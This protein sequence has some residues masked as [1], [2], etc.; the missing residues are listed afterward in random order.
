MIRYIC[1]LA[2]AWSAN[3]QNFE[4][5]FDSFLTS[6]NN[7]NKS[8]EDLKCSKIEPSD[9]D[10]WQGCYDCYTCDHPRFLQHYKAKSTTRRL[11]V[12]D[13]C[14]PLEVCCVH[15]LE[16]TSIRSQENCGKSN[17]EGEP[18]RVRSTLRSVLPGQYPWRAWVYADNTKL[19]PV[20]YIN[21]FPEVLVSTATCMT[22]A[23]RED[24]LSVRFER[25][26]SKIAN[27][28]SVKIHPNFDFEKND[29]AL[30]KLDTSVKSSHPVC[31][32]ERAPEVGTTCVV[33][34]SD[35]I[36]ITA[37]IPPQKNCNNTEGTLCAV[38][39]RQDFI[40]ETASG[41][42]CVDQLQSQQVEKYFLHGVMLS[43]SEN[44]IRYTQ[45]SHYEKWITDE[46]QSM[47]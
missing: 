4:S 21:F 23:T 34:T 14:A 31:R 6:L 17:P 42:F 33:V 25:D 44:V 18:R 45:I 16:V 7:Y 19:C 27:I 8:I 43:H 13:N 15:Q 22:I 24:N 47:A 36:T 32:A 9:G 10:I 41:L 35:D 46:I 5:S 3:A 11:I 39:P 20:S 29:I 28:I 30:I 26:P 38:V 1:L 12:D 37:I 2:I 40:P